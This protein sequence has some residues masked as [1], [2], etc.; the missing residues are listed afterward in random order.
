MMTGFPAAAA[1]RST[2]SV[3]LALSVY[4]KVCN[5]LMSDLMIHEF[6]NILTGLSGYLQMA[7]WAK[8]LES[9]QKSVGAMEDGVGRL[10]TRIRRM[11]DFTRGDTS[12]RSVFEAH[13]CAPLVAGLLDYHFSR[14]GVKIDIVTEGTALVSGNATLFEA[15]LLPLLID[16]RDRL[17]AGP[18]GGV[19][20]IRHR[21]SG[22]AFQL[23]M[24]DDAG[25]PD[26]AV[27]GRQAHIEPGQASTAPLLALAEKTIPLLAD[28]LKAK[29]FFGEDE[30]AQ[31]LVIEVPVFQ[32]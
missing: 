15:L 25:R 23:S 14:R 13:N 16:C 30:G 18:G 11:L 3:E 9:A 12:A 7:S 24:R 29:I 4:H 22:Q 8:D 20:H 1:P 27:L 6:N 31:A 10:I 5:S 32:C 26:P 28:A 17:M 2:E 19:I 21:S